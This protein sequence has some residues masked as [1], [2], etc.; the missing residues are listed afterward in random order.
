MLYDSGVNVDG[1]DVG[2]I[3]EELREAAMTVK[4]RPRTFTME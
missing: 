1:K 3:I 4:P 2:E